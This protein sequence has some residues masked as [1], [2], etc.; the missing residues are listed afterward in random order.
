MSWLDDSTASLNFNAKGTSITDLFLQQYELFMQIL[1][2]LFK[3]ASNFQPAS[4]QWHYQQMIR[5]CAYEIRFCASPAASFVYS[6]A[7]KSLETIST[8]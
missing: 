2:L 5:F 6:P 1:N 3:P 8:Q 7:T 4:N